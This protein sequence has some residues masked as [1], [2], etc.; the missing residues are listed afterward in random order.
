[1]VKAGVLPKMEKNERNCKRASLR[2]N[3]EYSA[4]QVIGVAT[5]ETDCCCWS[6]ARPRATATSSKPKNRSMGYWMLW[7]QEGIATTARQEFG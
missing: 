5:A 6:T 7:Q 1:M 4:L 3:E 2:H